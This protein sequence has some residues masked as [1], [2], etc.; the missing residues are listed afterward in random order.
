MLIT[1]SR[2]RVII[3]ALVL[4]VLTTASASAATY[5]VAVLSQPKAP[6]RIDECVGG[7]RD[8]DVGNKD[9][10]ADF[11]ASFTNVSS[12]TAS[13]VRLRFDVF[14]AFGEHLRTWY[15]TDDHQPVAAGAQQ[16]DMRHDQRGEGYESP[17]GPQMAIYQPV[18][19]FTNTADTGRKLVCSVDTVMFDS[20]S[21]W[22]SP[23]PTPSAFQKALTKATA[24]NAFFFV[25]PPLR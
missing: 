16:V 8:T 25:S 2:F 20:G 23:A 10:Y 7:T 15:G 21:K 5:A 12:S 17:N 11:V 13:A 22:Q 19:E 1:A 4:A 14:N 18:W 6:I 3:C 24:P 9:Y